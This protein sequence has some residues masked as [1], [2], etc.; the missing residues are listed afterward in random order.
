MMDRTYSNLRLDIS[1]EPTDEEAAAVAAAIALL[2]AVQ[3]PFP[4]PEPVRSPTRW[5]L[6]GRLAAHAASPVARRNRWSAPTAW[7]KR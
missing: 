6:T 2:S 5:A 1:P 3:Q 4:E 7:L